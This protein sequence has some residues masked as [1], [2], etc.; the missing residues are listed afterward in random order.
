MNKF[1]VLLFAF[2]I[3]AGCIQKSSKNANISNQASLELYLKT[4]ADSLNSVTDTSKIPAFLS[5][6]QFDYTHEGLWSPSHIPLPLRKMILDSVKSCQSLKLVIDS[7]LPQHK[8]KPSVQN[9]IYVKYIEQS[10]YDLI[11]FRYKELNC[12]L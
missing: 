6:P 4:F 9:G 8:R 11:E 3:Y 12:L 1:G 7:N 2:L 10:F 5:D